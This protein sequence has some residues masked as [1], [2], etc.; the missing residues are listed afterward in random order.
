MYLQKFFQII[1]KSFIGRIVDKKAKAMANLDPDRIYVENVRHLLGVPN[2][3]AKL[4]CEMAVKEGKFEKWYAAYCPN[5]E[6]QRI[7][8][9]SKIELEL[10]DGIHC[11]T[12]EFR[13]ET[14]FDFIPGEYK[15][16]V[17]YKYK[18]KQHAT[19]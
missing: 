2:G 16:D 5:S 6:C 19:N 7:V 15:I 1:D 4:I 9:S 13:G 3:L 10:K 18:R 8:A 11:S 17:F 14:K 12:C